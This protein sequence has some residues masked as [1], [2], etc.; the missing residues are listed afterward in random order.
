MVLHHVPQGSCGVVVAA[1]AT[2]HAQVLGA[3]NLDVVDVSA[4]PIRF[5]QCVCKSEDHD[6]LGRLFAEVVVDPVGVFLLEGVVDDFVEMSGTLQVL[7]KRL[8]TN[9]AGPF[10]GG[11]FVQARSAQLFH[12]LVKELGS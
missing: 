10:A 12:D 1:A 7:S 8:F 2:F 4:V 5:E 6:V 3:G 11:G 9:D